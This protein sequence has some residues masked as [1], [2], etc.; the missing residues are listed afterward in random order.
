MP[1]RDSAP[2]GEP[3]G[4]VLSIGFW[5]VILYL[6]FCCSWPIPS[7]SEKLFVSW[8]GRQPL[9]PPRLPQP[10]WRLYKSLHAFPMVSGKGCFSS[11]PAPAQVDD[12]QSSSLKWL[13]LPFF[14]ETRCLGTPPPHF[15]LV[16]P[17]VRYGILAEA[18]SL[19]NTFILSQ[20]GSSWDQPRQS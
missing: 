10:A 17:V 7:S 1:P 4:V 2:K 13:L 20:G 3:T 11:P 14:L 16:L 12:T 8:G 9:P 18:H 5:V 19:M 6:T 15:T